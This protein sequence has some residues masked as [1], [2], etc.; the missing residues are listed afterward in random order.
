MI[1]LAF[2]WILDRLSR[3]G[4]VQDDGRYPWEHEPVVLWHNDVAERS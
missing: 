2:C 4:I 1:T 3:A